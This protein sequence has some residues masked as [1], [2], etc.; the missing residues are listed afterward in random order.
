MSKFEKL[1]ENYVG[2]FTKGGFLPGDFV[3]FKDDVLSHPAIKSG[4]ESFKQK[5]KELIKSDAHLRI[6]RMNSRVSTNSPDHDG[7]ADQYNVTIYQTA[8][9]NSAISTDNVITVPLS[10]VDR[11]ARSSDESQMNV[12]QSFI[13]A[14]NDK[15]NHSNVNKS[16]ADKLDSSYDDG[17][18]FQKGSRDN[19]VEGTPKK[20]KNDSK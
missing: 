20:F 18:D 3:K 13:R 7:T 14:T 11:V 10:V 8:P 9:G 16:T 6:S 2:R 17:E 12:P 19:K 1:Y 4:D 5:I 15:I